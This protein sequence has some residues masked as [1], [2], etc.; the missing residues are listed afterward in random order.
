[1]TSN[2]KLPDED[3]HY[4]RVSDIDKEPERMLLPI[5]GY[6]LMPLVSLIEAIEPLVSIFP[7]I[8]SKAWVAQCNCET[9]KEGLTPDQS[10][11]IMLYTM[12]YSGETL[13]G[14][15]NSTLRS[16]KP[17][18]SDQLKPWFSYLK[19]LITALSYLPSH[20]RTVF[21]GIKL[22]LSQLYPVG[23][24]FVWWGFS[25]CTTTM[26]LLESPK[27]LGQTGMRTLFVIECF[28]GKNIHHHS[29]YP[30]EDEIL[31][32]AARHFEVMSCLNP[33]PDLWMIHVKEI[34]PKFAH[35]K[36]DSSISSSFEAIKSN[37]TDSWPSMVS[38]TL[39]SMTLSSCLK[40][41]V[42]NATYT[43]NDE[44]EEKK[45]A[46]QSADSQLE[47]TLLLGFEIER[48]IDKN[49]NVE[50]G[51]HV[52]KKEDHHSLP[53][54]EN[55]DS[56]S[57]TQEAMHISLPSPLSNLLNSKKSND[58]INQMCMHNS[59]EDVGSIDSDLV[60]QSTQ[61]ETINIISS[62]MIG[63]QS[64]TMY[65]KNRVITTIDAQIM[66]QIV[67]KNERLHTLNL[68]NNDLGDHGIYQ[69][70]LVLLTRTPLNVLYIR[71]NGIT[72]VGAAHLADVLAARSQTLTRLY[73]DGN[74]IT[75]IGVK[76]I[77]Q[78]LLQSQSTLHTLSF[79]K[80]LSIGDGCIDSI[81]RLIMDSKPLN[82]LYLDKCTL[83]EDGKDKLRKIK[84]ERKALYLVL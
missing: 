39:S 84:T 68:F 82:T 6:E 52:S 14:L 36:T 26:G 77:V 3:V 79:T 17:G 45:V 81:S 83:S 29:Y 24:Q 56:T 54:V 47:E 42:A 18:R 22:N 66:A 35:L 19:L 12:E 15:L 65:F 23:K 46:L 9:P 51:A 62:T 8:Q 13:Y 31:L 48:A 53:V 71:Q 63:T 1:M 57:N 61:N 76:I 50:C 7:D 58:S 16:D 38:D 11:A 44:N 70:T 67:E 74:K 69:L 32:V 78:A 28:T 49:K 55:T 21:R 73:L 41:E 34:R 75:D 27:F 20:Q 37:D 40:E 2:V 60:D 59:M 4:R 25:S 80:N 30:S 64:M 33:A 5:E 72:D 43:S 10:A